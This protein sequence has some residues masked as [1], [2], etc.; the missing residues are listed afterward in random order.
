L[1][2]GHEI[3]K[4]EESLADIYS[5][6]A[7]TYVDLKKYSLAVTYF[8]KEV[9]SRPSDHAQVWNLYC[10]LTFLM[11]LSQVC[12]TLL[13]IAECY[14]H[15]GRDHEQVLAVYKRA[16]QESLAAGKPHLQV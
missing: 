2:L 6:I 3:G 4:S 11:C 1:N 12:V 13:S 15:L 14:S 7:Q 10:Y 5:S 9:K 8:E 16:K